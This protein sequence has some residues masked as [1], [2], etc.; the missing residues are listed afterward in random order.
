MAVLWPLLRVRWRRALAPSLA[1]AL[2]IGVIG[3]FVLAAAASARRV[4]TAY[5]TLV[6]EIDA[7]DLGVIPVVDCGQVNGAVAPRRR[8]RRAA[9]SLY[10]Y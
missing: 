9:M 1:V 8:R 2:L 5:R 10:G 4:E 7:P 3:G 6:E